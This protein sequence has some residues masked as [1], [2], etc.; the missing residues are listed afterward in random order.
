MNKRVGYIILEIQY[1]H[2]NRI[3]SWFLSS[4]RLPPLL[5]PKWDL[6]HGDMESFMTHGDMI[7]TV[8]L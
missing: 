7:L 3:V 1:E 5:G 6:Y 2:S 4:Y 8:A